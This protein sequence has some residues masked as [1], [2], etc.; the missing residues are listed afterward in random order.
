MHDD[1][2][3]FLALSREADIQRYS[4][5]DQAIVEQEHEGFSVWPVVRKDTGKL[6]GRCGLHR[7]PDGEVEVAWIF[8]RDQWGHGFATEAA[9]AAIDYAK[10]V[11]RLSNVCA[12]VFPMNSASVAVANRLGMRFDRIVRAY[13]RDL[14]KY[15]TAV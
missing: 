3:A 15:V 7:M 12:L 13:Q 2:Q 11:A 1:A 9:R 8:A 5:V 14:L 6:I 4:G 10:D